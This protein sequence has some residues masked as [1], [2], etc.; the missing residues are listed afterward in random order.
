[1]LIQR[2]TTLSTNFPVWY[3]T[4]DQ[5]GTYFVSTFSYDLIAGTRVLQVGSYIMLCGLLDAP[6]VIASA[7]EVFW[8]DSR[9]NKLLD[10]HFNRYAYYTNT[11]NFA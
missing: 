1:M 4:V 5:V 7:A 2:P 9:A 11:G 6:S 3:S 8:T 10:C